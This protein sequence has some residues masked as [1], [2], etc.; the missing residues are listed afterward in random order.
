MQA[1]SIV[2]SIG[3]LLA[4][5]RYLG[6]DTFEMPNEELGYRIKKVG[7]NIVH[8]FLLDTRTAELEAEHEQHN[9]I[10]FLNSHYS[11]RAVRFG[12]KLY[13]WLK[14]AQATYPN[15]SYFGRVDDDTYACGGAAFDF[16]RRVSSPL[17][18]LGWMNR[19]TQPRLAD[20]PKDKYASL[21][22]AWRDWAL[23][24]RVRVRVLLEPEGTER[25]KRAPVVPV[26]RSTDISAKLE[27][28]G[29]EQKQR[30][31]MVNH[32]NLQVSLRYLKLFPSSTFV[33]ELVRRIVQRRYCDRQDGAESACDPRV[34][35][36]DTDY[37]G[38]SLGLWLAIYS[39]V[40]VI[41][42]NKK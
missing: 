9:D 18:Y 2:D 14:Y 10:H 23:K 24:E 1:P 15:A 29:D 42:M 32:S 13:L 33:F 30:T 17:M 20:S 21:P 28:A 40:E 34:D 41:R 22:V 11:G 7:N 12:E 4:S 31:R 27:H 39:D 37:G 19:D 25:G 38:T 35:L 8:K 6:T 3:V 36:Y 16:V 26:H 5:S